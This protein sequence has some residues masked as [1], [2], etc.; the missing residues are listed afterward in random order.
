MPFLASLWVNLEKPESIWPNQD[1]RQS[2]RHSTIGDDDLYTRFLSRYSLLLRPSYPYGNA[3]T[4]L[5]ASSLRWLKNIQRKTGPASRARNERRSRKEYNAIGMMTVSL[6]TLSALT[7]AF[8]EVH[9][10]LHSAYAS[11]VFHQTIA[12]KFSCTIKGNCF[13]IKYEQIFIIPE[14]LGNRALSIL[15][16]RLEVYVWPSDRMYVLMSIPLA[17]INACWLP[18]STV[19]PQWKL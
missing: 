19:A 18:S 4:Y 7:G 17:T 2:Q 15:S 6:G 16:L 8:H 14:K 10:S 11:Q 13:S 3:K 9:I 1:S 5:W 12:W